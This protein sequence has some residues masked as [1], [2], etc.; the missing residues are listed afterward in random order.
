MRAG[1]GADFDACQSRGTD[2]HIEWP[3]RDNERETMPR[4]RWEP[5]QRHRCEVSIDERFVRARYARRAM[6]DRRRLA[7]GVR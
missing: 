4:N 3:R 5:R 2:P 7:R 6:H 1:R